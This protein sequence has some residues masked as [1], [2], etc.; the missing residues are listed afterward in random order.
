M[1]RSLAIFGDS[2]MDAGNLDQVANI[3]R[4]DPFQESIYNRGGNVKAS[5][6]LVFGEHIAQQLGASLGSRQLANLI[7]L[8]ALGLTGFGS[9]QLRNFAYAGATSGNAGSRRA[10]LS[11]FPIGLRAQ[12]RAFAA[13]TNSSK[14]L[15]ALLMAGSN[16]IT[17]LAADPDPLKAFLATPGRGDDQKFEQKAARRIVNNIVAAYD[18]ITGRVDETVIL[19]LAPLSATPIVRDLAQSLDASM[20]DPLLALVD[21]IARRVNQGLA[22]R[23]DERKDVLVVDGFEVWS[24]VSDPVFLDDV[25]PTS[26]T[27]GRLAGE[28]VGL[29]QTSDLQS[30]GF[31]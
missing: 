3:V 7:T 9:Q 25:H 22:S 28:V 30:F 2:L 13:S 14:D 12:A 8:P 4:Q 16:D 24:Q 18:S 10:G 27:S 29:I 6:G 21:G 17:D 26:A 5:D 31:A 11:R 19:G 15:D 23:L 20:T 1:T